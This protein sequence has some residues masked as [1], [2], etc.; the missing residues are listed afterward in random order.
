MVETLVQNKNTEPHADFPGSYIKKK[1]VSIKQSI[2]PLELITA[3]E[4][5]KMSNMIF[6]IRTFFSKKN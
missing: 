1:S 4:A 3:W 6:L 2:K 5:A